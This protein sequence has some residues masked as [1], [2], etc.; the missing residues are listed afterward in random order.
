M[1]MQ[2]VQGATQHPQHHLLGLPPGLLPYIA[3]FSTLHE[4]VQLRC[5]S[6]KISGLS[7]IPSRFQVMP[8]RSSETKYLNKFFQIYPHLTGLQV[9]STLRDETLPKLLNLYPELEQLDL[10][11]TRNLSQIAVRYVA[12]K[13]PM[14][15][16]LVFANSISVGNRELSRFARDCKQ[17]SSLELSRCKKVSDKGLQML[18]SKQ[19]HLKSLKLA[20]CRGVT[21]VGLTHLAQ[22]CPGLQ[23][24]SLHG[25]SKITNMGIAALVEGSA[26]LS[27]VTI[28]YCPRI[29]DE[30][31]EYLVACKKLHTLSLA[32]TRITDLSLHHLARDATELRSLTLSRCRGITDIGVQALVWGS[33]QLEMLDLSGCPNV[34]HPGRYL[35]ARQLRFLPVSRSTLQFGA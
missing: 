31:V 16:K 13:S 34:P 26:N 5:S 3:S 17:L 18:V 22:G 12:R 21:D 33:R 14:V 20:F 8:K 7:S 30:V 15:K 10:S 6:K 1:S 19:S 29:T 32:R 4:I 28:S 27:S 23:E 24:I 11:K 9:D 25:S 35:P 2:S